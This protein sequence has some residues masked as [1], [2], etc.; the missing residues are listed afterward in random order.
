MPTNIIVVTHYNVNQADQ[1]NCFHR[2]GLTAA[3]VLEEGEYERSLQEILWE[4]PLT[5]EFFRLL[6]S[7]LM[8]SH[9]SYIPL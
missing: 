4:L 6:S 9:R 5:N 2:S 3:F 8:S 7:R 1:F